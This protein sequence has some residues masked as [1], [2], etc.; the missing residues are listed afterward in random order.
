MSDTS[1]PVA[2]ER[3]QTIFA[4]ERNS[5]CNSD[6]IEV[7]HQEILSTTR[8][9]I[10]VDPD[11]VEVKM[12]QR[13]HM[14]VPEIDREID[15][16]P[17]LPALENEVP[18][19][20]LQ[21]SR[22]EEAPKPVSRMDAMPIKE[23]RAR[24]SRLLWVSAAVA[25]IATAGMAWRVGVVPRSTNESLLSSKKEALPSTSSESG[26]NIEPPEGTAPA[27]AGKISPA[28]QNETARMG[29]SEA[30]TKPPEG[31]PT[32]LPRE[33]SSTPATVPVAQGQQEAGNVVTP[34]QTAGAH[35][36]DFTQVKLQNG[37]ELTVPSSGLETKL[38]GFLTQGS[39]KSG[40][41]DLD[42]ISFD[43]A[44]ATLSPS[45]LEQLQNVVKILKA[46]PNTRIAINAYVYK[47]NNRAYGLRL[48]RER[49]NSVLRELARIGYKSRIT[50]QVYEGNLV[51]RSSGSE[52][53]Q[54]VDQRISLTVTKT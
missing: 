10:W 15:T 35:R 25:I 46:Y 2:R 41:F 44:N 5:S 21:L 20:S 1:A 48:S 30:S 29:A 14:S 12:Q 23:P 34:A 42:G 4:R 36:D 6:L 39:S 45:S 26:T 31:A 3:L 16:A 50:V 33:M 53:G 22:E 28:P 11:K 13:D 32:T 27:Q 49:T 37:I 18:R 43:A 40:E 24:S 19:S 9:D 54:R 38:L 17:R 52:E 8:K 7:L 51:T 47:A